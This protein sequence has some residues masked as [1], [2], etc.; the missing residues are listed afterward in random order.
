MATKTR[1][2]AEDLYNMPDIEGTR[3]LVNGEVVE[4]SPPGPRHGGAVGRVTYRLEERVRMLG[5]GRVVVGGGF[6][7]ELPWDPEQVRSPDVA[8]VSASRLEGGRLPVKLLRGA[9]D[10]AVE[11]VSPS[12]NAGDLQQKV[13]D[14]L[15]AGARLVWILYPE[16]GTAA[17]YRPDGAARL[18][19]DRDTLDGDD[20]LPGLALPL[21]EVFD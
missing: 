15:G 18:L 17:T 14:Y 11:V 19:G 13:R 4:M 10:L 1:L 2:T 5:A 20:V 7:L 3:E 12:D 9:P 6:L 21:S 8:F 16:S